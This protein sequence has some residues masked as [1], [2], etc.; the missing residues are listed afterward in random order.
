MFVAASG[1]SNVAPAR[2]AQVLAATHP[3][4][5]GG[6]HPWSDPAHELAGKIATRVDSSAA[7]L[8]TVRN[9]SSLGADEAAEA[10]RALRAELR[11]EGLRLVSSSRAG[12]AESGGRARGKRREP[13][14]V[15]VTL[16][17][18]S[19]GYLWVAE[20]VRATEQNAAPD[21]TMVEA[22]R[23]REA[24]PAPSPVS[25]V[26]R[27]VLVWEQDEP[28]LDA[29]AIDIP[30]PCDSTG[31]GQANLA[32][33]AAQN[34]AKPSGPATQAN[35]PGAPVLAGQGGVRST[36]PCL[37]SG[38]LVLEPSKLSLHVPQKAGAASAPAHTTCGTPSSPEP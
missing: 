25:L 4:A 21:V 31:S 16:S 6:A 33:D 26:I 23:S 36:S 18:N 34:I 28:I 37:T 19:Q 13:D 32:G 35:T 2:A 17:E 9:M 10:H 7:I 38:L 22:A 14:R 24:Q 1:G 29:A 11:R 27:K 8:L 30:T 5:E 20:I 15:L 3:D 12:L